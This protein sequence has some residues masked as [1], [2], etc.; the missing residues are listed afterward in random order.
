VGQEEKIFWAERY[1]AF[2]DEKQINP[3]K[4]HISL[5]LKCEYIL[6]FHLITPK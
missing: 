2:P 4:T 1:Q 5:L 6:K 3:V